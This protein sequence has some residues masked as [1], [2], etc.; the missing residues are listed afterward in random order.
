M[1]KEILG[2]VG[3]LSLS[4]CKG[5][6]YPKE[7]DIYNGI[8]TSDSQCY[9]DLNVTSKG[10][11]LYSK[12]EFSLE[13]TDGFLEPRDVHVVYFRDGWANC[14]GF[15]KISVNDKVR[16]TNG[17]ELGSTVMV[18]FPVG[19]VRNLSQNSRY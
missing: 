4:G 18:R 7:I 19:I 16:I 8:A 9:T 12:L 15:P 1:K 10:V 6:N 14:T 2:L 3:M 13:V 11:H 17:E 5:A